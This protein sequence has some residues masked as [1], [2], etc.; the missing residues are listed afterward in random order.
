MNMSTRIAK[1]ERK[2]P[3]QADGS[4]ERDALAMAL[5]DPEWFHQI[6]VRLVGGEY[7]GDRELSATILAAWRARS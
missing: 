3:A 2:R 5:A 4:Q 6:G 7:P 1:L